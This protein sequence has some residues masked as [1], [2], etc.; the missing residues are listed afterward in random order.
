MAKKI[1][2]IT[3]C[4]NSENYILDCLKSIEEQDY[5][6]IQHIVIDGASTDNTLRLL[7]H[8]SRKGL[9]VY[10]EP[11]NGIYDAFN[12]GL[13]YASGDIIGF[14]NSDDM[15]LTKN[16]ISEVLKVFSAD[17]SV[18]AVYA[19]IDLVNIEGKLIRRWSSSKFRSW[20]LKFGW[21][22][23]HPSLFVKAECY[24]LTGGFDEDLEI[25]ADYKKVLEFFDD[26]HFKSVYLRQTVVQMR[27]G[28]ISNRGLSSLFKSTLEDWSV[29]R[30]AG[31]NP[32]SSFNAVFFK[33]LV[34]LYQFLP[35]KFSK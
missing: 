25:S 14:L 2:I 20:K 30:S 32:L 18:N 24:N 9:E 22:P 29:L 28:G 11:D 8:R 6:F 5:D 31:Y 19:D 27:T 17:E 15:Y 12:K 33:K 26:D 1:S 10:S 34:K 13:Q 16:V 35:A 3:A 23:P 7:G 21:M 4:Y